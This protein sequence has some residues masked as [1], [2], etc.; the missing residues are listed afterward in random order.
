MESARIPRWKRSRT[1]AENEAGRGQLE[2]F[3]SDQFLGFEPCRSHRLLPAFRWRAIFSLNYDLLVE[4]AYKENENPSQT[5]CVF[6]RDQNSI[7]KDLA[8]APNPLP[9]FKLH[10]SIDRLY[11]PDAPLILTTS[12]YLNFGATRKRLFRRLEDLALRYPLIF[13]GTRLADP[14]IKAILGAVER[15]ALGRPMYYFISPQVNSYEA[16]LLSK[17]R[18]TPI[19]ASFDDFM[20]VLDSAVDADDRVLHA[21]IPPTQHS[22]ERHFRRNVSA[23]PSI[24]AFLQN[25]VEHVHV[26]MIS[27]PLTPETF[28][29]GE[30]SR[31][32]RLSKALTSNAHRT[33]R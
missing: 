21:A 9:Y 15:D 27:P 2:R 20:E 33:R 8:A 22:I 16:S 32:F 4:D 7:E 24:I 30:I 5:I 25:N 29:K 17:Q 26:G 13:V 19:Q 23:P 12:S 3:I 11:E 28:Y 31:G 6:H 10:G 18:M 14:H 1:F